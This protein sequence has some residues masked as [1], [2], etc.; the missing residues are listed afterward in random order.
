MYI[1]QGDKNSYFETSKWREM[2]GTWQQIFETLVE[3]AEASNC[4][5]RTV[6]KSFG[7]GKC[8]C[9][10]EKKYPMLE[11]TSIDLLN[12]YFSIPFQ[13]EINEDMY[14]YSIEEVL[15][16]IEGN[17]F[18][19]VYQEDRF[20]ESVKY[21][22]KR[23]E[24]KARKLFLNKQD[25]DSFK[26]RKI[27][28][29]VGRPKNY[30]NTAMLDKLLASLK[31]FDKTKSFVHKT[32]ND[33]NDV[34]LCVSDI[35]F[36]FS[37][38]KN[39]SYNKDLI[40][41]VYN[42]SNKL[43]ETAIEVWEFRHLL[44]NISS[45]FYNQFKDLMELSRMYGYR[46]EKISVEEYQ[47]F[48]NQ[49]YAIKSR[50]LSKKITNE[51]QNHQY[52]EISMFLESYSS[53]NIRKQSTEKSLRRMKGVNRV[54]EMR[55][56]EQLNNEIE[57]EILKSTTSFLEKLFY[58]AVFDNIDKGRDTIRKR[59]KIFLKDATEEDIETISEWIFSKVRL[60]KTG[61]DDD[62]NQQVE[63]LLTDIT[64]NHSMFFELSKRLE[65]LIFDRDRLIGKDNEPDFIDLSDIMFIHGIYSQNY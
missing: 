53:G 15:Y 54:G 18:P 58:K 65:D 37:R 43:S 62:K 3:V 19:V 34:K 11:K 64:T 60:F 57:R 31:R 40:E 32:I 52:E 6:A 56:T 39:I 45:L 28:N 14:W 25:S 55:T 9:L 41:Y 4:T 17:E 21:S 26:I 16:V 29:G 22:K 27:S 50:S 7:Q 44:S 49:F 59:V 23:V 1:D 5:W 12:E 8:T 2:G 10:L 51:K 38:Y 48:K 20:N 47:N 42:E 35:E 33:E 36:Y 13:S 46:K 30:Y 63:Y 61:Y 24:D